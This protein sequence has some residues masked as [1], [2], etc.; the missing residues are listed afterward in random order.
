MQIQNYCRIVF[1]GDV[2][3]GKTS[4]IYK[5]KMGQFPFETKTTIANMCYTIKTGRKEDPLFQ[6]FD[7]AGRKDFVH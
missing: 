1:V 4:L 3:V 5:L 6:L 7:T 2:N